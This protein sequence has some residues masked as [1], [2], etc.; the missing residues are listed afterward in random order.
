MC[1]QS[2]ETVSFVACEAKNSQNE[3]AISL[4]LSINLLISQIFRMPY[5]SMGMFLS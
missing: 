1:K 2:E 3:F 5:N 4:L